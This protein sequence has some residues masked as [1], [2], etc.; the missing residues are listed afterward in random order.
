MNKPT[1]TQKAAY[2][3]ARDES[4]LEPGADDAATQKVKAHNAKRSTGRKA[5]VTKSAA[6]LR[7]MSARK[8]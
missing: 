8:K 1:P 6:L 3:D 4:A 2:N 7:E 5:N